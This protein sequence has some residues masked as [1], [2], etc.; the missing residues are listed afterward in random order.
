MKTGY[1]AREAKD[2][3]RCPELEVN[4][5]AAITDVTERVRKATAGLSGSEVQRGREGRAVAHREGVRHQRRPPLRRRDPVPGRGLQP[6]Q[7]PALPGRP[8]GVRARDVDR[9]LRRRS[10]Q[11]QLSPLRPG[12]RR[13][14]GSTGTA[15]RPASIT[16]W[17]GRPAG[18][19]EGDVT[20]VSG[21]PGGTSRQLTVAQLEYLRD[22]ALPERLLRLAELRGLLTEY[23]RRGPEQKRTAGHLLFSVENSLQGP[24]RPARRAAGQG[25]LRQ[26]GGRRGEAEGGGR[27]QPGVAEEQRGG[28]GRGSP[29]RRT[30]C[31]DLRKPYGLI[32]MGSGLLQRP[33]PARPHAGA[34]RRGAPQADRE[35]LPRV[36]GLGHCRPSP[37][38]CSARPPS[39]TSWRWRC[40]PSR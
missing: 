22:V 24:A 1:Y 5:L 9:L 33:V 38:G 17:P 10:R 4:Q 13:S 39:T 6:L 12:R 32:E 23:Q 15:S 26:A 34:R 36:P 27:R 8:P 37:S 25:V 16:T 31:A 3:L 35:A 14:C 11:L 29:R 2:E 28:L 40:S 30:S 19:A 21:H 20:F 7:V 18:A